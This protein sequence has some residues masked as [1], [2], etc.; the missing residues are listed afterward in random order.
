MEKGQTA[1]DISQSSGW[2]KRLDFSARRHIGRARD[3]QEDQAWTIREMREY[4]LELS[5]EASQKLLNQAPR[6]LEKNAYLEKLDK[7]IEAVGF[8]VVL[9]DGVGGETHGDMASQTACEAVVREY[10]KALQ[11]ASERTPEAFLRDALE[12]AH[13][14]IRARVR[15]NPQREGMAT[16]LTMA[17]IRGE[18]VYTCHVGDSRVYLHR[19]D[20]PP[21]QALEQKS[22]D[23]ASVARRNYL[24]QA[25]GQHEMLPQ[26]DLRHFQ[27][28]FG[29][30]SLILCSDGLWGE[31]A[32][33]EIA[34]AVHDAPSALEANVR[35][36]GL[37]NRRGGRDNISVIT[38]KTIGTSSD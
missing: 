17:L 19:N 23:H 34:Q 7:R 28:Q 2:L 10:Q 14:A 36:I 29:R 37:V 20:L 35:L 22:T 32:A 15:R 9:A 18:Q 3:T 5:D 13:G 33:A 16:T 27:L 24:L 6:M 11:S 12:D 25:V 4:G 8:L 26:P 21:D 30:D 38:V 1:N 31:G